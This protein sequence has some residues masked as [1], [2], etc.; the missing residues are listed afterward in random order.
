VYEEYRA[1]ADG[2][3]FAAHQ[4]LMA[5]DDLEFGLEAT[6]NLEFEGGPVIT[7]FTFDEVVSV[8]RE[9]EEL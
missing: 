5:V 6:G 9:A 1:N 8:A 2:T 7:L 3:A 4:F